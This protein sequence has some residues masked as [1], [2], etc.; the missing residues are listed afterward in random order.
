MIAALLEGRER[1]MRTSSLQASAKGEPV[2][3]RLGYERHFRLQLYER[4]G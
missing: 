1:G 4:R 3:E 2:Y